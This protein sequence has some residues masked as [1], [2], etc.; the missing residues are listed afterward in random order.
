MLYRNLSRTGIRV[1]AYALG[2]GVIGSGNKDEDECIQMIHQAIDSGINFLDTSDIYSGGESERIIG[3]ALAGRRSGVILATKVGNPKSGAV[4]HQGVSRTWIR[5]AVENS[6]R[7][8]QTDYIDLYQLHRPFAD[9]DFEETLDV[10]TDLVKEGKV[11]FIGTSNHQ[12]WQIAEAQAVSS[13]RLLQRFI[14]E[15]SPYS[16]LKRAIE[17][18]LAGAADKYSLGLLVYGPLAGGLLT[19]KYRAGH[20]AAEDSRAARY[21]GCAAGEALD[22]ERPENKNKFE[23]IHKLQT[24]AD[25]AGISLPHMAVAFTQTHPAV[26]ST[27]IGPRTPQQLGN[28]LSGANLQLSADVLDAIDRIVPPGSNVDD[29]DRAWTPDWLSAAQR[30]R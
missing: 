28:F 2:G 18:D 17:L 8:L 11:R 23:L 25:Q 7:S 9:T 4:N 19:G 1:S 6:L 30:R 26:T 13:R 22:P 5:Q 3:K 10:L 27:I 14:S 21:K 29:V 16:I 20:A 15:Q 24:V 12:A